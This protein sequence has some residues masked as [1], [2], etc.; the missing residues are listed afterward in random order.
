MDKM[1]NKD[2][3]LYTC[4]E[5]GKVLGLSRVTVWLRAKRANIGRLAGRTRVFTDQDIE[6]VKNVPDR[7]R[8]S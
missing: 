1:A 3:R 4:R 7:R 8:K 2:G 5:V 6:A